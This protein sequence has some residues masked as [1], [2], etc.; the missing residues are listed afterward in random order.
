MARLKVSGCQVHMQFGGGGG[1]GGERGGAWTIDSTCSKG[2]ELAPVL[3][4]IA[5]RANG[6]TGSMCCVRSRECVGPLVHVVQGAGVSI[7][8]IVG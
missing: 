2:Q 7:G 1:G 6:S 8:I 5:V 3:S 4:P